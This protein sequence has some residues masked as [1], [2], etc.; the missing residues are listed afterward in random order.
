M[1]IA[2]VVGFVVDT[3]ALVGL[4]SN[5][6][7]LSAGTPINIEIPKINFGGAKFEWK[8]ITLVI[9]IYL[10]IALDFIRNSVR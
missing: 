2:T 7:N 6:R 10:V 3:V 4:V 9:I 5:L 8:D 1:W